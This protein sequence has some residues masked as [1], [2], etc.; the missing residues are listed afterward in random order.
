[1]MNINN[2]NLDQQMQ[3]LIQPWRELQAKTLEHCER[4]A[5]YQL[6]MARRYTD[7]TLAQMREASEIRST[8][9]LQSYVRKGTEAA[10][11]TTE[12]LAKDV[13]T[14]TQL[15]QDF[16]EDVQRATRQQMA[17]ASRSGTAASSA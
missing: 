13:R 1:M 7:V 4:V 15:G 2:L 10:R 8:E 3:G 14:L 5:D 17:S 6:D 12:S 16:A 9:E 11:E